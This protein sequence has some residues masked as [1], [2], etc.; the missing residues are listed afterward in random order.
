LEGVPRLGKSE[1]SEQGPTTRPEKH[2]L[3]TAR[4]AGP[5]QA[6]LHAETVAASRKADTRLHIRLDNEVARLLRLEVDD[7]RTAPLGEPASSVLVLAAANSQ[8]VEA[9]HNSCSGLSW[10]GV[11]LWRSHSKPFRM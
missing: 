9:L 8:R 3:S 11:H 7:D 6:L 1:R 2:N 5:G 10:K 4:N